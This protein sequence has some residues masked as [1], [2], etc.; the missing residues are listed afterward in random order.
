VGVNT[1]YRDVIVD[2]SHSGVITLRVMNEIETAISRIRRALDAIPAT[3]LASL[4]GLSV[5]ALKDAK[6]NG[7]NPKLET[8]VKV[9]AY[10]D[11]LFG[12]ATPSSTIAAGSRPPAAAQGGLTSGPPPGP[13][14]AP[15]SHAPAIS[16]DSHE[17]EHCP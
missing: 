3:R 17:Q 14:C 1:K 15:P 7:W 8:V 11:R 12:P 10:L 4:S 2:I 13:S 9:L 6:R 16:H 5:N